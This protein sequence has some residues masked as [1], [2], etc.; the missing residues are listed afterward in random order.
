MCRG[1]IAIDHL[2][3]P[4]DEDFASIAMLEECIPF[5]EGNFRLKA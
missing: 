5:T 4:N 2:D 3:G 1:S